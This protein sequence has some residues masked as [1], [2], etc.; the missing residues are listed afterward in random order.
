MKRLLFF[1]V[2]LVIYQEGF[3]QITIDSVSSQTVCPDANGYVQFDVYFSADSSYFN[4]GDMFNLSN[5]GNTTPLTSNYN[6]VIS[7]FDHI[8][9]L[10]FIGGSNQIQVVDVPTYMYSSPPFSITIGELVSICNANYT[11]IWGNFIFFD[12][13]IDNV[14]PGATVQFEAGDLS[15]SSNFAGY[16]SYQWSG[17][18][19]S[20]ANPSFVA[21]SNATY[22]VNVVDSYG[23]T[24]ST[25]VSISTFTSPTIATIPN[26]Q[27][28][29]PNA[30]SIYI[31][32]TSTAGIWDFYDNNGN[33]FSQYPYAPY[34]YTGTITVVD[35]NGCESAPSNTFT[36]NV[37]YLNS[38]FAYFSNGSSSSCL[39]QVVGGD[40]LCADF[41]DSWNYPT[42]TYLWNGVQGGIG[43]CEFVTPISATTYTII[44]NDGYG[45]IDTTQAFVLPSPTLT[46]L[47]NDTSL[48]GSLTI[49][50]SAI[51]GTS[52]YQ[53]NWVQGGWQV[54][55][56]DSIVYYS[57]GNSEYFELN[58]TDANGCDGVLE[59]ISITTLE[60]LYLDLYADYDVICAGQVTAVYAGNAWGGSYNYQYVWNP[61]YVQGTSIYPT[62][63]VSY[64]L[65]LIDSLAPSCASISDTMNITVN[66]NPQ[67]NLGA[68]TAVC[69]GSNIP[70]NAMPNSGT[71]PFS[72]TWS[73]GA[74]N[75]PTQMVTPALGTSY[76]NVNVVD[77]NG[78]I[79]GDTI[80]VTVNAVPNTP[81]VSV[82]GYVLTSSGTNV[83]WQWYLNGVAI[84]G[85]TSQSYTAAQNGNYT[86][87]TTNLA[88]CS[89]EISAPVNIT[90][91][92]I[93]EAIFTLVKVYPNPVNNEL[94]I[95]WEEQSTK[96]VQLILT[97]ISGKMLFSKEINRISQ[98][99]NI[100]L[101]I[102][103]FAIGVYFL[104]IQGEGK[105]FMT[106]IIKE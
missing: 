5:G 4:V 8:Y 51:G 12:P 31:P 18:L 35:G 2:L 77:A 54:F 74:P 86:V 69:V 10:G 100:R 76:Y 16:A 50:P 65:T 66:P 63:S 70:L 41:P 30:V 34:S 6:G 58:V 44:G 56:A 99:E 1:F 61:P 81:N 59:N 91:V 62:T 7:V 89:S 38:L 82:N 26:Q 36:V 29:D 46:S 71:S 75:A 97:D 19:P 11:D 84:A 49:I 90:G 53:Y 55:T 52:P 98:G 68:D 15:C 101:E 43:S 13:N 32:V 85:A 27:F 23:C 67:V 78:C 24:S 25:S 102:G 3:S 47:G 80:Q 106:K 39:N 94:N 104:R 60:S 73:N 28:C 33:V 17:G 64:I 20:V 45:C 92:A 103:D 14:C 105:T 88:G 21:S 83:T 72:Y 22:T 37:G 9:N 48:C 95:L 57:P 93:A 40:N 87:V 42:P 96:S 79:G